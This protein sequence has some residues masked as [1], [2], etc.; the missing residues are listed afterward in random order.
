MPDVPGFA[1][2]MKERGARGFRSEVNKHVSVEGRANMGAVSPSVRSRG[3]VWGVCAFALS[4]C[5]GHW[6]MRWP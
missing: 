6:S 4:C 2:F 5:G 1:G 3:V